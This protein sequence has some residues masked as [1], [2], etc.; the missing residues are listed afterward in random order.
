LT[1][2]SV[3]DPADP[4]TLRIHLVTE[5]IVQGSLVTYVLFA[6]HSIAVTQIAYIIGL[7]AWF[8]QV[9][10]SRKYWPTR[11]PVDV[12]LLGF[13]NCCVISSFLSYA[14][15]IS[16]RGLRS[17]S[18]F[19]AFYLISN[20]ISSVRFAKVLTFALV[21]S[22]LINVGYSAA[23][24][25]IGR[26]I[27]IDSIEPDSPLTEINLEAGDVILKANGQRIKRPEDIT[28]L[29]DSGGDQLLITYQR[30]ESIGEISLSGETTLI[31]KGTGVERL[32]I[33]T[34]TGRNFRITGFYN[35][36]ETYA[37]VLALI[38]SL[39]IG[40]LIAHPRKRSAAGAFLLFS[41]VSLV[42]ALIMTST[43][44]A[45]VGLATATVVMSLASFRVRVTAFVFLVILVI[46]PLVSFT[47]LR[48]RGISFIDPKE[49]STA[50][51][52]VVWREALNLIRQHPAVGIGKGSDGALRERFGLF[53]NGKLP[54]GHFHSS[55]IQIATWW[56]LPALACYASFMCILLLEGWKLSRR[57]RANNDRQVWGI[58]LGTM[59]ALVAFNVSSLVHWNFGD[60]EV[61]MTLWLMA[62]LAFAVRRITIETRPTGKADATTELESGHP[63]R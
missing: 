33:R 61:V 16:I 5:R 49:G 30:K 44:A 13:F 14:P 11:M 63:R 31:L 47:I 40:L 21:G 43:R 17:P 45:M 28:R 29:L 48:S 55:P 60:G 35:H 57:A 4:Y 62:G 23:Q 6:P 10:T 3:A 15:L 34:S 27:Q 59:G 54:P 22:C 42:A 41:I 1:R 7:A 58:A 24:V 37:E 32:G 8:V 38:A 46:T 26:G 51:R 18:L 2:N 19:L 25:A 9:V 53:D 36:Y 50:Y 56:G 52:L 12:A 39:A 20:K